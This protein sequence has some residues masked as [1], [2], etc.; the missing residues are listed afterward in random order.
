MN[1]GGECGEFWFEG[2]VSQSAC[3][4]LEAQGWTVKERVGLLTGESL[5]ALEGSEPGT[6]S[7]VVRGAATV[8]PN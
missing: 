1:R 6:V 4:G 7:P 2:S 5:Q 3:A 8:V